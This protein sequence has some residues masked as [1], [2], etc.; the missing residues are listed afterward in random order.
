M[1]FSCGG[2]P[3]AETFSA[4]CDDVHHLAFFP[5]LPLWRP[6]GGAFSLGPSSRRNALRYHRH[7]IF[8]GPSPEASRRLNVIFNTISV[9]E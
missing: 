5:K 9:T 7:D 2:T 3:P 8:R 4:C 1:G 6:A